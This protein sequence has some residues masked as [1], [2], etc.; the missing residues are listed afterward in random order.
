MTFINQKN[1]PNIIP[2]F[3]LS[4]AIFFPRTILPLNIFE[5]RYIQLIND[6]M[7]ENRMLG[8]V[9]PKNKKSA[10]PEVY[11]V[12]CLGKI[13]SFNETS[14]KRFIIT[15]SGIS[16]FKIKNEIKKEKLYRN[17]EVDYSEFSND[18]EEKNK[19]IKFD[20]KSLID[21]IR[22]FFQKI[23]YPIDY[24]E[25]LKLNIDQLV[26]TVSMISPFSVEEKQKLI[27]TIKI[28]DKLKTLS[29]II[30]FNLLDFEEN[31]T[32]Q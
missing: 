16:R 17:F 11:K 3:P 24:D 5:D 18:L 22:I 25:L 13:I 9:Q 20:N 26:S 7:K 29:E 15:L 28:E 4:G 6:C 12:G 2:V 1:L 14:D 23:N 8:M 32:V 19:I 10:L 31:K 27:E 21:K 30:N